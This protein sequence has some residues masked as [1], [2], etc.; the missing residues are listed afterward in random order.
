[1]TIYWTMYKN[2]NLY[3]DY[4]F[5]KYTRSVYI[6]TSILFPPFNIVFERE[7]T[8]LHLLFSFASWKGREKE[9]KQNNFFSPI[10]T[11]RRTTFYFFWGGGGITNLFYLKK[12]VLAAS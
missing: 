2:I 8:N 7:M 5:S 12:I 10:L 3:A 9:Q 6:L 11:K 4:S 1:M